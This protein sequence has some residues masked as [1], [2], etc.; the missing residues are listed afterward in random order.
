MAVRVPCLQA[1]L[2]PGCEI[3]DD[4]LQNAF[5]L[6]RKIYARIPEFKCRPSCGKCCGPH[7]W[8]K[9][10]ENSI[11]RYVQEHKIQPQKGFLE[12]GIP[13]CPYL[14]A[15]KRCLI[16]PVRPLICRLYGVVENLRCPFPIKPRR[17][18]SRKD[19]YRLTNQVVELS[20]KIFAKIQNEDSFQE[21]KPA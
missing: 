2:Q 11:S 17:I 18:L 3:M 5:S 10:E 12:P 19:A 21:W 1:I 9:L 15:D 16:F 20:G 14:S 8:S 6:L 13:G 7:A 4:R